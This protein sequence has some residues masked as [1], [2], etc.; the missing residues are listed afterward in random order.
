MFYSLLEELSIE[1]LEENHGTEY[2]KSTECKC[3][4]SGKCFVITGALNHFSNRD[5]LK[6]LLENMNAKV[7]GS[8]SKNTFALVCNQ[9]SKSSKCKKS[10]EL[11]IQIW[12]EDKLLEYIGVN[13]E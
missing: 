9:D 6:E 8:V 7:S 3:D 11:G 2:V 13:I 5:E 1:K 10:Q 4:L 12:T